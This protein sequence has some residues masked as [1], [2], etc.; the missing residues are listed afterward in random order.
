[1]LPLILQKNGGSG[2]MI[3]DPVKPGTLFRGIRKDTKAAVW[4]NPDIQ[5]EVSS[6]CGILLFLITRLL[7]PFD[8]RQKRNRTGSPVRLATI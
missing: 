6:C 3:P 4:R 8:G 1:M 5:E 2:H 7:L